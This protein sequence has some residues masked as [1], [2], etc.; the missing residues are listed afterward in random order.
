MIENLPPELIDNI[1]MAALFSELLGSY[2]ALYTLE[3]LSR[4]WRLPNL[5]RRITVIF[6]SLLLR[7]EI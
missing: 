5:K 4:E 6:K 1:I 2:D 7:K 3:S